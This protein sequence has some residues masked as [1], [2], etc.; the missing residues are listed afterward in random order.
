MGTEA[1]ALKIAG[2]RLGV[3]LE[4]YLRRRDAGEKWYPGCRR[5]KCRSAFW[6]N[7]HRPDGRSA[8]CSKCKSSS[9]KTYYQMRRDRRIEYAREYYWAHRE[10]QIS[11][12]RFYYRTHRVE[13]LAKSRERSRKKSRERRAQV[14]EHYGGMPPRC[15]CYGEQKIEFL[16]IGH[17]NGG[18]RRERRA[19]Q[20]NFHAWVV[21]NGYPEGHQVLCMNCNFARGRLGHRP[22]Q[23]GLNNGR[24]F[25]LAEITESIQGS[26]KE[27]L[28]DF[29]ELA[30][31]GMM[32]DKLV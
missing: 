2:K 10:Q 8:V 3:S 26:E 12:G 27:R 30:P 11:R 19:L 16:T 5:W 6:L 21:K 23:N 15:A 9:D 28:H 31:L 17:I 14:L 18:G 25:P 29:T 22:H 7:R 13:R 24:C 1:G 20:S 4:E 32:L